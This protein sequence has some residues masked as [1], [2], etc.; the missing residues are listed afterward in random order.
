[1]LNSPFHSGAASLDPSRVITHPELSSSEPSC[2]ISSTGAHIH[3]STSKLSLSPLFFSFL[4]VLNLCLLSPEG[5]WILSRF[6]GVTA[7]SVHSCGSC[8]DQPEN[9][10]KIN[11]PS[12]FQVCYRPISNSDLSC[13]SLGHSWSKNG[14]ESADLM[15]ILTSRSQLKAMTMDSVSKHSPSSGQ[16]IFINFWS[17]S[18]G[19]VI[20]LSVS[21]SPLWTDVSHN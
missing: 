8:W 7:H 16:Y 19:V 4:P 15:Q 9:K 6:G 10:I 11:F 14:Q 13:A 5:S 20:V 2:I 18:S 3:V 12:Y 21:W 1:M 17:S